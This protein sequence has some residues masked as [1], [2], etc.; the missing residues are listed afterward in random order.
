MKLKLVSLVICDRCDSEITEYCSSH[1]VAICE[2]CH[3]ELETECLDAHGSACRDNKD[4][5]L[6]D[7]VLSD[8]S[9]D[10]I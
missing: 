4:C 8:E 5:E 2:P 10:T 7:I 6:V 3:K 1:S 9:K